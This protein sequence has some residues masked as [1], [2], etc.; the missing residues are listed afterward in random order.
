MYSVEPQ[1]NQQSDWFSKSMARKHLKYCTAALKEM[2]KHP[3]SGLFLE[4]VDPVK[5]GIPD[6][7]DIIKQ[8][9]DLGTVE[10]KLNALQYT[11]VADFESDVR[12]IFSNCIL[13]NGVD[14][15]VSQQAR[16]LESLFNIQLSSFPGGKKEVNIFVIDELHVKKILFL[17]LFF[18]FLVF[19][20]IFLHIDQT[21]CY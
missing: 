5:Y 7:F 19:P 11:T 21:S 9:M 4:P 15:P 16:E 18:F 20:F 3:S 1:Q 2:K 17:F 10:A 14:H 12:L 8:P 6:Y 13:Y